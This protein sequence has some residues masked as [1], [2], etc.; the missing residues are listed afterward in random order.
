MLGIRDAIY[1]IAFFKLF[2]KEKAGIFLKSGV[3]YP[4]SLIG[5]IFIRI[6]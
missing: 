1:I 4:F 3:F 5:F 2:V 6:G